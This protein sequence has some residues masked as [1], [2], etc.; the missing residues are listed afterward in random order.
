MEGNGPMSAL[1]LILALTMACGSE[2]QGDLGPGG[3]AEYEIIGKWLLQGMI[4][5]SEL[6]H[7][8]ETA[9]KKNEE[10]L[11]YLANFTLLIRGEGGTYSV[12]DK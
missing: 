7:P 1:V 4:E 3:E 10:I 11:K 12:M 8:N 9:E 2:N 5:N 6:K